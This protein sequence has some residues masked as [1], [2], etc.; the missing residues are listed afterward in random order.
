MASK[1]FIVSDHCVNCN[2]YSQW[3]KPKVSLLKLIRSR[4]VP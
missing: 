4:I 1:Y 2:K 3:C